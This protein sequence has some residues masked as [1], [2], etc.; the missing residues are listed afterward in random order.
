MVVDLE[1]LLISDEQRSKGNKIISM[2]SCS[3]ASRREEGVTLLLSLFGDFF[4]TVY[5][6]M[7][8]IS[9]VRVWDYV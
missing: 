2:L 4:C 6:C 9:E 7:Q 8:K 3:A 5:G 1:V